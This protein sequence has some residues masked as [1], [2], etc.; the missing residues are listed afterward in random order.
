[1]EP[2]TPAENIINKLGGLTKTARLLSTD[3]K[4]F[5]IST[6][7]GWKDRGE[8]PQ[9][10]WTK[11]IEVGREINVTINLSAFLAVEEG[12]E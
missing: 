11:L 5:P 2:K 6:V 10:H 1:M 3:D 4:P 9:R 8:I 7:Q 12:V